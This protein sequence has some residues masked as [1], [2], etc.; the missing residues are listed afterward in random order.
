MVAHCQWTGEKAFCQVPS[1]EV[2]S[3]SQHWS[4][5]AYYILAIQLLAK[6]INGWPV[7]HSGSL[8]AQVATHLTN[9][10]TPKSKTALLKRNQGKDD[11]PISALPWWRVRAKAVPSCGYWSKPYDDGLWA[12]QQVPVPSSEPRLWNATQNWDFSVSQKQKILCVEE[13]LE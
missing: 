7:A 12:G 2:R 6:C 11:V 3:V 5:C 4:D 8:G 9:N 10:T 13:A 1:S